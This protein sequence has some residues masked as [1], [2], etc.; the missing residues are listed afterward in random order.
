MVATIEVT[1][2]AAAKMM[3]PARTGRLPTQ[4]IQVVRKEDLSDSINVYAGVKPSYHSI[5]AAILLFLDGI[6]ATENVFAGD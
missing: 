3:E 6:D 2:S 1:G 5:R 4:D